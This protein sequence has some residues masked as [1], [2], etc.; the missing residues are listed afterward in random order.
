MNEEKSVMSGEKPRKK[1]RSLWWLWFL[2]I[3]AA[4]AGGIVCGLK[5]NTLPLPTEVRD[6]IYPVL[7]SYIPGSTTPRTPDTAAAAATP[8]PTAV[9]EV[10]AIPEATAEPEATAV[11][12]VTA[13]PK[14]SLAP[15]ETTAPVE[16]IVMPEEVSATPEPANRAPVESEATAPAAEPAKKYIGVSAALDIALQHAEVAEEDAEITGVYRTKDED[17]E[18][19]YEVSFKSGEISYD[20]VIGAL[21]GEIAGWKMSG[22]TYSEVAAYAADFTGEAVPEVQ[23]TAEPAAVLDPIG[24][25]NAKEIAYNHASVKPAEVLRATAELQ[26][27]EDADVYKVEFKTASRRF[28]YQ[29]DAYTGEVLSHELIK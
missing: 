8:A 27:G 26:H 14:A 2:L 24:E 13:E 20:Y 19:V 22:F 17:G 18:P 5:I 12:E 10:T 29:I 25:E 28:Q 6:R 7:E 23:V 21:D 3:L 1:K 9:P 11:P 16:E 15:E 4:F